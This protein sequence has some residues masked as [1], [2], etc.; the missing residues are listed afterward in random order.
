[1]QFCWNI[2]NFLEAVFI[3]LLIPTGIAW[4]FILITDAAMFTFALLFQKV[5]QLKLTVWRQSCFPVIKRRKV[6]L[7]T[8]V[9]IFIKD[10]NWVMKT[11]DN[12][13]ISNVS[14]YTPS[15][16]GE[17][18]RAELREWWCF[19]FLIWPCTYVCIG[20]LAE[21]IKH[22]VSDRQFCA[23]GSNLVFSRVFSQHDASSPLSK[24]FF[25]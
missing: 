13:N 2:G 10:T 12:E 14:A 18:I 16:E 25:P 7:G 5:S 11:D 24:N 19:G 15:S 8:T 9:Y 3:K 4:R 23:V 17:R 22:S 21:S 1:M 20:G 6:G